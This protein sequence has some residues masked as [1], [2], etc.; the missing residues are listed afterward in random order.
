MSHI[1]EALKKAQKER[2][3]RSLRYSGILAASG[4]KKRILI[5]RT[6]RWAFPLIIVIFLAF[7]YDSWLDFTSSKTPEPSEKDQQRIE[8]TPKGTGPVTSQETE[9][10]G[11]RAADLKKRQDT[12]WPYYRCPPACPIR[13]LDALQRQVPWV[14]PGLCPAVFF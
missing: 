12:A 2:D 14:Y 13:Y 6:I 4:S 1:H 9:P 5:R 3:V 8:S 10:R 7:F 11:S